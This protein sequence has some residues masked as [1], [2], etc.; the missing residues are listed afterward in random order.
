[1]FSNQREIYLIQSQ[2]NCAEIKTSQPLFCTHW[3]S[4]VPKSKE[5][6]CPVS[7]VETGKLGA[8]LS[9]AELSGTLGF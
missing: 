3:A 2:A 1:M 4:L 5:M 7:T 8:A 6:L 9:D